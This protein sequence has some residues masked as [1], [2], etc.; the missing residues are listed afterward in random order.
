MT[1]HR[2]LFVRRREPACRDAPPRPAA[3]CAPTVAEPGRIGRRQALACVALSATGLAGC[4]SVG[5]SRTAAVTQDYASSLRNALLPFTDRLPGY[6]YRATP[7]GNFGV[8]SVYLGAVRGPDLSRA[9]SGWFLGGPQSWLATGLPAAQRREWQNRLIAE[10]SFGPLQIDASRRRA[11]EA[12]LGVAIFMAIG[13]GAALD[14]ERGADVSFRASEVRSRRLNW[15]EF[16]NASGA[17]LVAR[18]VA[19]AVQRDD[20]VIA[21]ADVVL[22]DYRAEVAVDESI[23]PS[24][25]ASLRAKSNALVA[26]GGPFAGALA[27]HESTRGHFVAASSQPVV[28]AVL[29]KRP[30]PRPK[31]GPPPTADLDRWPAVDPATSSLESVQA[32]VLQSSR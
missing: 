29:Y 32:R 31:G 24:L 27:L 21:A 14:F 13:A 19:D 16:M 26:K 9:E 28:A 15:A 5:G 30:P 25:G 10:G 4:G 8:G 22:L 2:S 1:L 17:G 11:I 23:N 7:L 6:H 3:G 12:S 18:E 20:F